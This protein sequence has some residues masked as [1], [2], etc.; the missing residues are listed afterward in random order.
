MAL[1]KDVARFKRK[2][3]KCHDKYNILILKKLMRKNFVSICL[4]FF[5]E[6]ILWSNGSICNNRKMTLLELAN[7]VKMS[8]EGV[9]LYH[10]CINCKKS[11]WTIWRICVMFGQLSINYKLRLVASI[12][13]NA[14]HIYLYRNRDL[15][16]FYWSNNKIIE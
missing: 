12:W 15:Y 2:L 8:R 14:S 6:K 10:H 1:Q 4:T 13:H 16:S 11:S 7:I 3:I 5:N 9:S